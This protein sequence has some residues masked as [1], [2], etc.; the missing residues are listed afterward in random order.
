MAEIYCWMI[1]RHMAS[2]KWNIRLLALTFSIFLISSGVALGQGEIAA[3]EKVGLE[4]CV[5]IAL[6]NHPGVLGAMGA[7]GASRSRVGEARAPYWPQV[8]ASGGYSRNSVPGT[9]VQTTSRTFNRYQTSVDVNQTLLDFGKT[10]A[11]VDVQKWGA[12]AS[13]ED[14]KDVRNRIVLGVKQSYYTVV[15]TRKSREAQAEAVKQFELHLEQAKRFYGVGVRAKIDVTNAEVSLGQAKLT[16]I[17]AV[18]AFKV[19]KV[20]LNNAMGLPGAPEYE[21]EETPA[22]RD[23]PIELETALRRGYENRPDLSAAKARSEGAQRSIDVAGKG[24]YPVLSGNAQYGWS[25]QELP[26]QKGWTL[27]ATLDFPLFSGYLTKYQVEEMRYNLE[28]AKAN[29]ATIRQGVTLEIQQAYYNLQG[30]REKVGVAELTM[31]QAVENRE[32]AQGRYAA[33]VGNTIEVTDA[34]VSEVNARTA[35]ITAQYDYRIAVANL[36]QAMGERN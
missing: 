23:Y 20:T 12:E 8:S 6:K 30:V 10:T 29:E 27:G 22:F 19:A 33:G 21:I 16:L 1:R 36:E 28:T 14:L 25:G 2:K 17:N 24:Y 4:K 32:L 18:N 7:Y 26:L 11:Q 13:K 5:E 31:K 9:T 3:G 34:V 15:Q 35:W